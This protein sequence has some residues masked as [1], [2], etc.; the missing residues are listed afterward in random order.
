MQLQ[1]VLY[2]PKKS[3]VLEDLKDKLRKTA[4][5]ANSGSLLATIAVTAVSGASSLVAA[6]LHLT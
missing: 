2:L 6:I 3:A 5:P 1:L 4:Q